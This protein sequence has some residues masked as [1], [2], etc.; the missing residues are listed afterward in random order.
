MSAKDKQIGGSHYK[1]YKVQPWDIIEEYGLNFWEGNALKYLLR[2]KKDRV[3]DL[4]KAIHYLEYEI[5]RMTTYEPAPT[6]ETSTTDDR[7]WVNIPPP[8]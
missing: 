6:V 7:P 5:E 2:R 8:V 3:E 1:V 4:R